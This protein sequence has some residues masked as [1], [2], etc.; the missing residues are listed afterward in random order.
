MEKMFINLSIVILLYIIISITFIFGDKKI[1]KYNFKINSKSRIFRGII[2]LFGPLLF[3]SYSLGNTYIEHIILFFTL[4]MIELENKYEYK[5]LYRK[6]Q[7]EYKR[8]ELWHKIQQEF[9]KEKSDH[10]K[11]TIIGC[12]FIGLYIIIIFL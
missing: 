8:E 3:L 6:I 7:N 4:F 10:Q 11:Q 12:L 1:G 5:Y 9:N 2:C